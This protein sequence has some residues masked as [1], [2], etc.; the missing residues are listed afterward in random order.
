MFKLSIESSQL[1]NPTYGTWDCH[2][3]SLPQLYVNGQDKG[4]FKWMANIWVNPLI[5]MKNADKN[6]KWE[7]SRKTYTEIIQVLQGKDNCK[8]VNKNDILIEIIYYAITL[9]TF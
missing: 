4:V 7:T 6:W 2:T 8:E 5:H 1:E 3:S 9:M